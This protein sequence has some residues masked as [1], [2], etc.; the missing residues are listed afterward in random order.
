MSS[1]AEVEGRWSEAAWRRH[2]TAG[3]YCVALLV[4][5]LNPGGAFL[6]LLSVPLLAAWFAFQVVLVLLR[7]SRWR[8]L[9]VNVLA[10]AATVLFLF[11]VHAVYERLARSA[12]DEARQAV[13]GFHSRNGA[14]PRAVAEAGFDDAGRL[15]RW[16]VHYL[17]EG[18][19]IYSSTFDI[20]DRWY[21]GPDDTEWAFQAD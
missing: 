9:A 6:A 10:V 16:H 1:V 2:A 11:A 8:Y 5:G 14:W 20:F 7:R 17:G 15:K 4:T 13:L 18:K 3:F 12:A 21:R 19:F